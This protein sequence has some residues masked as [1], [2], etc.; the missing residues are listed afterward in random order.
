M[1]SIF[2]KFAKFRKKLKYPPLYHQ[3]SPKCNIKK[4]LLTVAER[5]GKIDNIWK[6]KTRNI[7]RLFI[8]LKRKKAE[9]YALFHLIQLVNIDPSSTLKSDGKCSSHSHVSE[10]STFILYPY[11]G[12]SIISL[13]IQHKIWFS[14]FTLLLW[15]WLFWCDI[16]SRPYNWTIN[17]SEMFEL[18][19]FIHIWW[20]LLDLCAKSN[21]K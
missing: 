4:L 8:E 6:H 9:I 11:L 17:N 15:L 20:F 21:L 19:S 10:F 18:W 7:F 5:W 1:S 2:C 14:L 3:Y 16:P 13:S 12:Y